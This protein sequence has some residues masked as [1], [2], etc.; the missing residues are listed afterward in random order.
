V[1]GFLLILPGW[2]LDRG[3]QYEIIRMIL[4]GILGWGHFGKQG[5]GMVL[6]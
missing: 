5:V 2:T 4:D 1:D 3:Q 6:R